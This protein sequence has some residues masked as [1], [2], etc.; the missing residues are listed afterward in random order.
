MTRSKKNEHGLKQ[1]WKGGCTCTGH[2][3]G[4]TIEP[5][6][7][8]PGDNATPGTGTPDTGTTDTGTPDTTPATLPRHLQPTP[9]DT[10]AMPSTRE[11]STMAGNGDDGVRQPA[12]TGHRSAV[13]IG[14]PGDGKGTSKSIRRRL[15]ADAEPD[16]CDF[17]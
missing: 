8:P 7:A 16:T 4:Q 6:P 13:P 5:H 10:Q 1:W 2:A 15:S 12:A 3:N 14:T 9:I 17:N 11:R